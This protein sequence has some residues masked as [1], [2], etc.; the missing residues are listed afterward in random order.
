MS[1]TFKQLEAFYFSVTLG[2]F[3]AAAVQLHTTQ[4]AISKRIAELEDIFEAVLVQRHH[5]GLTATGAG[6]RLLKFAQEAV[7]LRQRM[8]RGVNTQ[9]TLQGIFRIG[10]TELVA[11]TWLSALVREMHTLHPD[12]L[13]EPQVDS[14]LNL[15]RNLAASRIDLAIIPGDCWDEGY[16]A[17]EVGRVSDLWMASPSLGLPKRPLK[18]AEFTLHPV[19]RQSVDSAKS[20]FYEAWRA[21]HGIKFDRVFTTNS[22][23]VR[24]EMV[25]GGLGI[26]QLPLEYCKRDIEQGLLELVQSDPTPPPIAYSAVFRDDN[27]GAVTELMVRTSVALC[28][29]SR[30]L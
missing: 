7:Q 30:A 9:R 28:N 15:L 27:H 29:F 2:S 1:A 25:I 12:L 8:E 4:S 18:P 5:S 22:L 10:V 11:L 3:T 20:Q 17:V 19:L 21:Q 13:L 23:T 24:R 26:S 14:G 16:T 6:Q